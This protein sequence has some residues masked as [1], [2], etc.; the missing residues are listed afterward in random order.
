MQVGEYFVNDPNEER[1]DNESDGGWEPAGYSLLL[2]VING[3]DEQREKASCDH[4]AT[5]ETQ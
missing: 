5:G 1:A 4:H 2:G 3:G